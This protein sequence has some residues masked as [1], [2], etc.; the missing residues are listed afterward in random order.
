MFKFCRENKKGTLTLV[1]VQAEYFKI[2]QCIDLQEISRLFS[3]SHFKDFLHYVALGRE[4]EISLRSWLHLY[5]QQAEKAQDN[6]NIESIDF[7]YMSIFIWRNCRLNSY[8]V[9]TSYPLIKKIGK[10]SEQ[11]FPA[12]ASTMDKKLNQSRNKETMFS[13][14][15]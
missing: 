4:R 1:C 11:G 9:W 6:V 10:R 7:L 12:I 14:F 13:Y 3:S 15:L 2:S 8:L 5:Y